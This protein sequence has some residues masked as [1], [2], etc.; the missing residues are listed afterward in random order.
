LDLPPR[1]NTL[2]FA[3]D[4]DQDRSGLHYSNYISIARGSA[5]IVYR[6]CLLPDRFGVIFYDD[7]NFEGEVYPMAASWSE[8]FDMLYLDASEG[9]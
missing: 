9:I 8:F 6:L 5:Q 1:V 7:Q 4:C 3:I 2:D